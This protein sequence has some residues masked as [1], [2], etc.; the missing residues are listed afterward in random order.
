MADSDRCSISAASTHNANYLARVRRVR[1][2]LLSLLQCFN[3]VPKNSGL[4][5]SLKLC[6]SVPSPT[7]CGRFPSSLFSSLVAFLDDVA[8]AA[9]S[10][11]AANTGRETGMGGH[12][13]HSMTKYYVKVPVNAI[14]GMLLKVVNVG[15][16]WI[17]M[18]IQSI[19]ELHAPSPALPAR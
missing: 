18:S 4:N 15:H 1:T 7:A 19:Y 5:S 13:W 17:S 3:R 11:G 2:L 10:I 14:F 12:V 6:N 16:V 8:A 9:V